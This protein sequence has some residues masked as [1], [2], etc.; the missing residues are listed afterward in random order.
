MLVWTHVQVAD[1][2]PGR[3]LTYATQQRLAHLKQLVGLNHISASDLQPCEE[4]M[5][6][7][8]MVFEPLTSLLSEL[9]T[10]S[11]SRNVYAYAYK[12]FSSSCYDSNTLCSK[13]KHGAATAAACPGKSRRQYNL[14]C[15][16][17][18]QNSGGIFWLTCQAA[19]WPRDAPLFW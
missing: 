13:A 15:L 16:P 12:D 5:A 10:A 7:L 11:Q 17:I 14:P 8:L 4:G 6:L 2:Q 19:N 18:G 1:Q 3:R 9:V